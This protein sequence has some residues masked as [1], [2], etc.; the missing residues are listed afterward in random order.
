MK[1]VVHFSKLA[2]CVVGKGAIVCP[3]DHT[4]HKAGQQVSNTTWAITSPVVH[5]HY[6]EL[7][8]Q[9]GGSLDV[10]SIMEFETAN[11]IYRRQE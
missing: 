2:F 1:K 7:Y 9:Q 4:N 11:T 3:I 10:N 6:T 8:E 5:I